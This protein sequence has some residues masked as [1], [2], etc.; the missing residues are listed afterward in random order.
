MKLW[1]CSKPFNQQI[2]QR[3]RNRFQLITNPYRYLTNEELHDDLA[4]KKVNEVIPIL[5]KKHEKRPIGHND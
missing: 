3:N 2:I 1:R 5:A 4:M